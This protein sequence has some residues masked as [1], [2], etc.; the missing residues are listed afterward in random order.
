MEKEED[1]KAFLCFSAYALLSLNSQNLAAI[2]GTASLAGSV[3][4]TRLAA[5]GASNDAGDRQLPM[6]VASLVSSRLG[7]FTLG[8][9]HLGTPP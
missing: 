3:G 8:Y 5:L 9:C 2:V 7:Y 4:Q 1:P 6:G